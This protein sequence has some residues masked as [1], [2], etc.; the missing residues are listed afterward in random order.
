MGNLAIGIRKA[1]EIVK[2]EFQLGTHE[3]TV[4]IVGDSKAHGMLNYCEVKDEEN[5]LCNIQLFE[6][7]HDIADMITFAEEN[8]LTLNVV[9]VDTD[10]I[11]SKIMEE[12]MKFAST[13][14]ASYHHMPELNY[15]Q[16]HK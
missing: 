11:H 16:L 9:V 12:G 6:S 5:D 2:H 1:L 3:V 7:A 13:S 14:H 4:T 8:Q 10:N 15:R